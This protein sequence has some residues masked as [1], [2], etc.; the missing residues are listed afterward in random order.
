MKKEWSSIW[1]SA[2]CSF[3]SV[4]LFADG[5]DRKDNLCHCPQKSFLEQLEEE[6]WD[7]LNARVVGNTT[8]IFRLNLW[9]LMND[10]I[11]YDPIQGQ[12]HEPFKSWKSGHFQ[13][14]SSPPF[15]KGAGNWLRIFKI[16]HNI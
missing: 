8:T 7:G 5:K 3:S 14:L 11:H 16:W 12:G 10:G 9:W 13:K 6:N 1:L 2:L 4:T 15:M